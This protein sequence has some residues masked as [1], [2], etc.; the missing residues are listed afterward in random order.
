[1]NTIHR[2]KKWLN[3]HEEYTRTRIEYPN[4]EKL[5]FRLFITGVVFMVLTFLISG[6]SPRENIPKVVESSYRDVYP[7]LEPYQTILWA[8]LWIA[9]IFVILAAIS[10]FKMETSVKS[11]KD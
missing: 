1:M 5:A 10:F 4:R 2:I 9:I 8:C 3:V 7:L 6:I 11:K